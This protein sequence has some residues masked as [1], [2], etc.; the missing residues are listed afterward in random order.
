M[1]WMLLNNAQPKKKPGMT[2]PG[3]LRNDYNIPPPEV[4]INAR[5]E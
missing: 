4:E 1:N 5:N 2:K 3:V